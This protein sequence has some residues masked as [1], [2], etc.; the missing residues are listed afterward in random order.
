MTRTMAQTREAAAGPEQQDL[1]SVGT[2]PHRH[3]DAF[4]T[5]HD[6]G[7]GELATMLMSSAC[8]TA[9]SIT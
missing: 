5:E 8:G 3:I 7:F 4:A 2:A 1:E 6:V 9:L